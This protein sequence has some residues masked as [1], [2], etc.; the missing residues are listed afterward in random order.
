MIYDIEINSAAHYP[1]A[2]VV[3]LVERAEQAGLRRVL[4][5]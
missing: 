5:R 1:A 3:G 2:D 4:E